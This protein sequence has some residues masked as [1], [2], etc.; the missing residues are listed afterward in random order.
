MEAMTPITSPSAAWTPRPRPGFA[1]PW[2]SPAASI[3]TA[4]QDRGIPGG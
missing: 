2:A 1:I 3:G 4:A